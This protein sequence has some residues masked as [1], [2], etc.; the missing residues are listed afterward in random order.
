MVLWLISTPIVGE[1]DGGGANHY[2]AVLR[3]SAAAIWSVTMRW[4]KTTE[5]SG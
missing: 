4:D 1:E 2:G 3:P 5:Q